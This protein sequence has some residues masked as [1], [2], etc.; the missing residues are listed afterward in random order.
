ME[1]LE[2]EI[3]A[4]GNASGGKEK[5]FKGEI[6]ILPECLQPD[7]LPEER[8]GGFPLSAS[9]LVLMLRPKIYEPAE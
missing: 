2:A 3:D 9:S 1:K 4:T 7:P 5:P 8:K 6:V